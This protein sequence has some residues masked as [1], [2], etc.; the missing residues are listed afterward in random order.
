MTVASHTQGKAC[1]RSETAVWHK[2]LKTKKMKKSTKIL[3][4]VATLYFV[5]QG[6]R[7]FAQMGGLWQ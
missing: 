3:L 5:A 6:V 2:S 7:M 4:I 1:G